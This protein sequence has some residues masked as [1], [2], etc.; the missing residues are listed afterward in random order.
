MQAAEERAATAKP[1]VSKETMLA[2]LYDVAKRAE[3]AVNNVD[4][5]TTGPAYKGMSMAERGALQENAQALL[6]A[7]LEAIQAAVFEAHK[8]S[9]EDVEFAHEFYNSGPGR[10]RK[11]VDAASAVRKS[12]GKHLLTKRKILSVVRDMFMHQCAHTDEIADQIVAAA[13]SGG[14][15]MRVI[16]TAPIN[17]ANAYLNSRVG[18]GLQ[19]V[20]QRGQLMAMTTNDEAF[21]KQVRA[22]RCVCVY[23]STMDELHVPVAVTDSIIVVS[24]VIPVLSHLLTS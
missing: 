5:A 14:D 2:I 7:E 6:Q 19:D 20:V 15:V 4:K 13:E 10:D 21:V 23:L 22:P 8:V 3:E 18:M 1:A 17:A 12:I 16:Q 24:P 11:I 9:K